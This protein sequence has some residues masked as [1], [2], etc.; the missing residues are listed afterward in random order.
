MAGALAVELPEALDIIE[1]D[2]QLAKAL[3]LGIDRPDAGQVQHRVEQHR[4]VPHREHEAVAVRPNRILGVETQEALPQCVDHRRQRH[5]CAGVAGPR[6]LDG[7]HRQGADGVDAQRVN[8]RLRDHGSPAFPR[9]AGAHRLHHTVPD[10]LRASSAADNSLPHD[11]LDWWKSVQ[12]R[13]RQ[14]AVSTEIAAVTADPAEGESLTESGQGIV[15][16]VSMPAPL[17]D[18]GMAGSPKGNIGR[19]RTHEEADWG[20]R[21]HGVARTVENGNSAPAIIGTP[22]LDSPVEKRSEGI[23]RWDTSANSEST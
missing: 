20:N 14:C 11:L 23:G 12:G 4:R 10:A 22:H 15:E 13:R 1:C 18:A 17:R 8:R 9:P 16:A 21:E 6:L 3:V 5:G 19:E 7:I 2:G